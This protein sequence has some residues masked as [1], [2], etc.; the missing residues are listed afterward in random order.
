MNYNLKHNVILIGFMGCGKT[1]VG[2]RLAKRLS[3]HFQDTDHIIEQKVGDTIRNLFS[4]QG[5]EYF[6]TLETNTLLALK[7]TLTHTVLSTGGG[8][9]LKA[10]NAKILKELGY[11]V[12]L[13][14]S[15]ET[16]IKRLKDDT[17]RPLLAGDDLEDKVDRLLSLR[18]PFYEK[19]AH[20]IVAT[21][22]KT[23]EEIMDY[24]MEA[25]L[26]QIS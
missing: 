20:K 26:K 5:E 8:L 18:T 17:T 21:D 24:I 3:Y 4:Q 1:S 12:F 25:Y 10:Q 16:T 9:P 7:S 13:K 2:E 23:F 19:A 6:R 15:K 11:V 22:G 14:A